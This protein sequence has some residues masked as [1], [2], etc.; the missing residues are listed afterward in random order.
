[1]NQLVLHNI[2]FF[3]H[4]VSKVGRQRANELV[5]SYRSSEDAAELMDFANNYGV[6]ID[7]VSHLKRALQPYIDAEETDE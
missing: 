7:N 1:L 4:I 3:D 6:V 2:G 5:T